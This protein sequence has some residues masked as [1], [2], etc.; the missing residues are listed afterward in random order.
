[1]RIL[2]ICNEYP[3]LIHGGIGSFTKLIA[4]NLILN[5][6][7]AIVAGYGTMDNDYTEEINGVPVLRIKKPRV[8]RGVFF[9][10]VNMFVSRLSFYMKIRK[11]VLVYKPDL[12]ETY[13][14]SAPLIFRPKGCRLVTRLHGSNTAS[15]M[16]INIRKTP[17]LSCLERKAIRQSD[18][19]VSVSNYIAD[20]TQQSFKIKFSYKTIY[21]GV[22]TKKFFDQHI[23]RDY[24]E[25]LLVGRMHPYKGFDDLFKAMNYIFSHNHTVKLKIICTV[26][27]SYKNKLMNY[28]DPRFK[29]RIYF[30][31]RVPNDELPYYYNKA[32]LTVL[33]SRT[34]AFPIIPLESMACGTPV[35]MADRFSAREIINGGIDGFLTDTNDPEKFAE[36]ICQILNEQEAIE[37]MRTKC[38]E[39]V[40]EM[41][42][43]DKVIKNN[44]E[45]YQSIAT[46][47]I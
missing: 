11:Y 42:S 40:L 21:N 41:F 32:N 36:N 46:H 34:E 10:Y 26:I 1:M 27:E 2:F 9:N 5:N 16:S 31:G 45:F 18:F 3:P 25:I 35:I 38:R 23:E 19:I 33:P 7:E 37:N 4:E 12:V 17:L 29:Y 30:I 44:I 15:N 6:H 14:W 24:D 43:I 39:K 8:F 22:D 20:I 28:V 13:D 47:A